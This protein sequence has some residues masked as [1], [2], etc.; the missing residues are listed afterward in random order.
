[1]PT[2]AANNSHRETSLTEHSKEQHK[3]NQPS[4]SKAEFRDFLF[5]Q[6]SDQTLLLCK[7]PVSKVTTG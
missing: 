7:A 2:N 3:K 6:R 1:M 4:S 5:A